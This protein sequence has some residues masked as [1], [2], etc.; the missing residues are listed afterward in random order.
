MAQKRTG[1]QWGVLDQANNAPSFIVSTGNGYSAKG[2]DIFDNVTPNTHIRGATIGVFGIDTVEKANTTGE[3]KRS[4]HAG[5]NLRTAFTG[6]RA[7]RVQY[8]TLVTTKN[9][10]RVP[11]GS[12][13]AVLPE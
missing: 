5:W 11:D 9:I 2:T 7:G 4:A 1:G 12:D 6:G 13:D 10:S 3:G 8:E